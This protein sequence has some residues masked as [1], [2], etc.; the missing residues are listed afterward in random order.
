MAYVL[1]AIG[2]LLIYGAWRLTRFW[3]GVY[4]EAS[5]EVDRRW[6]AEAKLVEMA[7]WFGI[8]GLKDEEERELPRYLRR[9]LGE[10]GREGALRADEL[11]YLGIQS[12]AEGR[13][14]FWRLPRREGEADDSYA[15]VEVNEQGEALFY[16]WGD[17]T[18][19]LGQAAL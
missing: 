12:N 19:A 1:A 13:A 2:L 7:P 5:A 10:V 11:Q 15:Y 4:A 16:G 17:R 3:R 9:E 18:P 14:H 6:E 8:T